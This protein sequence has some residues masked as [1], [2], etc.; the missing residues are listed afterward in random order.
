NFRAFWDTEPLA[1]F[2]ETAHQ[3]YPL[4]HVDLDEVNLWVCRG[5]NAANVEVD[6][7]EIL[8]NA[9]DSTNETVCGGANWF[10]QATE[11]ARKTVWYLHNWEVPELE[12]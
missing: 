9:C 1:L 6:G 2:D 8:V 11:H 3:A 10:A 7:E 4:A 5:G 12:N